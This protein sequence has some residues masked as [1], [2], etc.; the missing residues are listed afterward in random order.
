M[1]APDLATPIDIN[2]TDITWS[3]DVGKKFKRTSNSATTQWID[4]ENGFYVLNISI[5]GCLK[6]ILLY[7]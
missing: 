7:G 1:L 3:D 2:D 5:K 6:N 4:P